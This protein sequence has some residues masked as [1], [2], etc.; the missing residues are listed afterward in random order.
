[1]TALVKDLPY[2]SNYY[3]QRA[4]T[5][6]NSAQAGCSTQNMFLLRNGTGIRNMTLT[7]LFGSLS[8]ANSYGTKRP[9]AGAYSSLDPGFGPNDANAWIYARSPYT[10]N[11]TMFG[12]GCTGVKIDASLHAGGNK[13]IVAN[14]YTT[15]L[16]D[17]IGAW[18]TGSGALTELISVFCYYSYSGYLSELG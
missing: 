4:V 2:F 11:V 5:L 12:T 18:C 1:M 15:V 8:S 9:T 16:S 6:Y 10:Q 17:G 13:S 7:G 14:D 3:T